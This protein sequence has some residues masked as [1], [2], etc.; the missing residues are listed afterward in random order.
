MT[1]N[2]PIAEL[3]NLNIYL[4]GM[5]GSGK[6]T[7]GQLLA[8]QVGYGFLDTD[9][10]IERLTK[11]S[12]NEIFAAIGE[13]KFRSIESQVLAEVSAYTKLVVSTGG[14]IVLRQAN[15]G[16]LRQGVIVWLD[17]S[18]DVLWQRLVADQT[19]PLLQTADPRAKLCEILDSRRA[20]YGEADLKV[21]IN[22]ERPPS[23]V[24]AEIIE[25][26]P[27]VL[28]STVTPPIASGVSDLC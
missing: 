18:L 14:G 7:I 13:E 9:T 20:R 2:S 12:I 28:K 17:V 1:I 24:A 4:V 6:S 23:M 22:S 5:M 10:S 26:I 16:S 8:K 25:K 21:S 27:T 11:Q 15:W 3:Q 19:R